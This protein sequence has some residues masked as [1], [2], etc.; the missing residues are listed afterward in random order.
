MQLSRDTKRFLLLLSTFTIALVL[1]VRHFTE[2][3]DWLLN[4]FATL[5]PFI[6][7][8]CLA[9]VLSVPMKLFDRLLS[10]TNNNTPRRMRP[11]RLISRISTRSLLR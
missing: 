1:G 2:I 10:K 7:G 6:V 9:F 8:A 4:A 5:T 3:W 11:S